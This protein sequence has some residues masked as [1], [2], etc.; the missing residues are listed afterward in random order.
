MSVFSLSPLYLESSHFHSHFFKLVE[1]T[2]P[3]PMWFRFTMTPGVL[4]WEAPSD[5]TEVWLANP[6][7]KRV[8]TM[9]DGKAAI[10]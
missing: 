2:S 10:N 8:E 6:V 4:T 3:T 5:V 1:P 9:W 7:G